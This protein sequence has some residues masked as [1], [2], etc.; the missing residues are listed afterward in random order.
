MCGGIVFACAQ[1]HFFC[2]PLPL[3]KKPVENPS[4]TSFRVSHDTRIA[5]RCA[6]TIRYRGAGPCKNYA[7]EV[8]G[9]TFL[10]VLVPETASGCAQTPRYHNTGG[11]QCSAPKKN[12]SVPKVCRDIFS[13]NAIRD[14]DTVSPYPADTLPHP[15][16]DTQITGQNLRY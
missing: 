3:C 9:G 7:P 4:N 8:G 14:N 10:S 6:I 5:V 1:Q 2:I 12:K 13:K 16:V 15:A 11:G